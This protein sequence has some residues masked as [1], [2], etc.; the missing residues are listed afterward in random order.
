MDPV[1]VELCAAS[2]QGGRTD[3]DFASQDVKNV[4]RLPVMVDISNPNIL[5]YPIQHFTH[6]PYSYTSQDASSQ[7]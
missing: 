7:S 6:R 3:L 4:K 5:I 1:D 2:E